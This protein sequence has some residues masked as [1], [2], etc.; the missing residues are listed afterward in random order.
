MG[1]TG[2]LQIDAEVRAYGNVLTTTTTAID[3]S[4][5]MTIVSETGANAYVMRWPIVEPSEEWLRATLHVTES[6]RVNH[7]FYGRMYV[8]Y[9]K[10]ARSDEKRFYFHRLIEPVVIR[11]PIVIR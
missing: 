1:L 5:P 8:A 9:G 6:E 4:L 3:V 7:A 11:F 10:F 2:T